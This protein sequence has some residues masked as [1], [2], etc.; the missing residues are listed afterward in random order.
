MLYDNAQLVGL[1]TLV[2]QETRE[3]LYAARVRE[4]VEWVL[5]EMRAA[6]GQG[7][8]RGFA[9]SLD[10]DSEGEEGKFYVWSD[11]EIDG[12][13]GADAAPFKAA[14]D[15]SPGGNWEGHNILNRSAAPLLADGADEARLAT[16]RAVLLEA[17]GR[18]VRW[19]G[20]QGNPD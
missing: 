14:Y 8:A 3:P 1:L 15:V 9:S 5:R 17:R 2:W 20:R 18:R 13:L 19:L 11:S 6:P 16:G 7:G 4:T 12:L 10:A